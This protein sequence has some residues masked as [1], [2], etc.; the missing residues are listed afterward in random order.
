MQPRYLFEFCVGVRKRLLERQYVR[1]DVCIRDRAVSQF[2]NGNRSRVHF[3]HGHHDWN[4]YRDRACL[5]DRVTGAG[6]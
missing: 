5:D 4:M 6:C 2:R 1:S 3:R